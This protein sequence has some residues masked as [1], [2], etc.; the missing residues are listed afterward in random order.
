MS[1]VEAAYKAFEDAGE[2]ESAAIER[3]NVA[4][5]SLLNLRT[6]T[7][8]AAEVAELFNR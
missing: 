2:E 6:L 7:A 5:K 4:E 3:C 8:D 1:K